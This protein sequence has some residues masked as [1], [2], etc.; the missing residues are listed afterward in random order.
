MTTSLDTQF[1]SVVAQLIGTSG[2]GTA[3]TWTTQAT[4]ADPTTGIVS[5]TSSHAVTVAS[6]QHLSRSL[7]D[8]ELVTESDLITYLDAAALQFTPREGD[9]LSIGSDDYTVVSVR[10]MRAQD[11]VV[12]Y[13][14]R[15][16]GTR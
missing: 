1:A 8:G 11:D 4:V 3:A 12:A 7:V 9:R 6:P 14:V 5:G 10:P 16:R 15:I 2:F 13:E